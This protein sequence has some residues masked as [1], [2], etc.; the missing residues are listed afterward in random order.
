[1]QESSWEQSVIQSS[2]LVTWQKEQEQEQEQ[3]AGEDTKDWVFICR[4]CVLYPGR[5]CGTNFPRRRVAKVK[6]DNREKPGEAENRRCRSASTWTPPRGASPR[7]A[8]SDATLRI[9]AGA[10]PLG[11]AGCSSLIPMPA[12][13]AEQQAGVAGPSR[14]RAGRGHRLQERNCPGGQGCTTWRGR[15]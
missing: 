7:R 13:Q 11:G 6:G 3:A 4:M 1:M 9:S 14:R 15:G 5:P 10:P 2:R 8:P 12:V